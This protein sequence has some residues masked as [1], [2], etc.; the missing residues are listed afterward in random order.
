MD[1]PNKPMILLSYLILSCLIIL[2]YLILE[3]HTTPATTRIHTP[4]YIIHGTYIHANCCKRDGSEYLHTE[5]TMSA[6]RSVASGDFAGTGA[7]HG[8]SSVAQQHSGGP[9]ITQLTA[10]NIKG[11]P[12]IVYDP[13]Y[14]GFV[15]FFEYTAR[16][17]ALNVKRG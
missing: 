16:Y 3:D 5:V 6:R 10:E 8:S 15:E 7:A 2:P 14:H 17:V 12:F 9:L 13:Q 1:H 11:E 4:G